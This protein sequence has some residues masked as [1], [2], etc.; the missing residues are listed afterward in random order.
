MREE[1]VVKGRGAVGGGGEGGERIKNEREGERERVM[2][3]LN[4][5]AIMFPA[6]QPHQFKIS[7]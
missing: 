6:A 7:K 5:A 3:M 1:E 4:T 2:N